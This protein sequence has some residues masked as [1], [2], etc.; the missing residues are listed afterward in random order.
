MSVGYLPNAFD[1]I[2]VRD[3]D[4]IDQARMHCSRLVVGVFTDDYAEQLLGRRPVVPMVE[5]M[6]LVAHV[7]GVDQVVEHD[8]TSPVVQPDVRLFA[9]AGDVPLPGAGGTWLLQPTRETA[10]VSLREALQAV[11][12][13]NVA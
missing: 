6:A 10:S 5:R 2:N 11:R 3:L 9:V 13:E 8:Q 1:L 4:L 12:Q 7:R